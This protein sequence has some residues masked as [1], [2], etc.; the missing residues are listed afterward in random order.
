MKSILFAL[1]LIGSWY[2]P[3][4]KNRIAVAFKKAININD[5]QKQYPVLKELLSDI[6]HTDV[7]LAKAKV[8]STSLLFIRLE[9]IFYRG[10]EGTPLTVF[11][12]TGSGYKQ[13]LDVTTQSDITISDKSPP[14]IFLRSRTGKTTAWEYDLRAGQYRPRKK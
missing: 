8:G 4:D 13:V 5:I 11:M 9:G 10:T 3:Q 14:V 7:Y 6:E 12:D 2:P 1:L